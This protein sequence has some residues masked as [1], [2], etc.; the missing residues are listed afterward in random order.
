MEIKK[1]RRHPVY[2]RAMDRRPLQAVD[3]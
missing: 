3:S 2:L 1:G